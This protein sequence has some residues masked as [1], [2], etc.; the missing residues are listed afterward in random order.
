[1]YCHQ[2]G[3][4]ADYNKHNFCTN[5]GTELSKELSGSLAYGISKGHEKEDQEQ[6]RERA[7]FN[8]SKALVGT[9]AHAGERLNRLVGEKGEMHVDLNDV[10]SELFRKHTKEEAEMLF[11]AGTCATTPKLSDVPVTWPKPWLFGRVFLILFSTYALL[12]LAVSLFAN[13]NALPGLI[14]VGSFAGPSALLMFFW[15]MNAPQ[16]VSSY[17]TA[18]M[19]FIGGAASIL[20]SLFLYSIF[21]VEELDVKGAIMVAFIEEIGKLAIIAY[22]VKRLNP[23]YILNGL[24]IGAAIG[25][26][27]AA[28]ESAG[29]AFRYMHEEG[30]QSMLGIIFM[31]GWQSVGGHVVWSAIT[32]AALTYVKKGD[33]LKVDHVFD[34]QFI[35]L[36][37][38]PVILHA[39]WDLTA[40]PIFVIVLIIAAWIFIF[41][42]MNS[43][44]KQ[45]VRLHA[46]DIRQGIDRSQQ[47]N[48]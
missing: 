27:F 46:Y 43:G 14:V 47:K 33:R 22:F 38:I 15:E 8:F 18:K 34:W 13:L 12:Y 36:F 28:F 24:L 42:L 41:I 29:Y 7:S 2:C 10:F 4:P 37:A 20:A 40:Y 9:F 3:E 39:L 16:N 11:A 35:R 17:E 25:A 44:L 1:M 31:R 32:G 26:G 30:L 6:V 45:L 19:F 21:P 48:C 5:C 23:R